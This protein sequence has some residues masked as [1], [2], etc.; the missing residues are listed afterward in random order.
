MDS[1]LFDLNG[2]VALVTGGNGG[3]GL[4]I[5]DA[6][7]GAGADIA[8]WGRN[9]EK[10]R[11]AL[12]QLKPHGRRAVAF[13]VDV[14]DGEQLETGFRQVEEELGSVSILVNNAGINSPRAP[15][16][17]ID[18]TQWN[19]VLQTNLTAPLLLSQ[20]A[21]RSMVERK[22]GKIINIS[23]VGSLLPGI[24]T[25]YRASKLALNFLT[26]SLAIELGPHNIQ[27]NAILPGVIE[28]DMAQGPLQLGLNAILE[29]T[30]AGRLGTP[31]EIASVAL[32]LASGASNF[33][34]GATIVV[35]GGITLG[36][37]T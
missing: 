35:D 4:A 33:T 37:A 11:S 3:I 20:L 29:R 5:A 8:I 21:G 31:E 24:P 14:T 16:L 13:Q 23:S 27:V 7:A 22:A 17:E 30:P 34:T 6:F 36:S 19:R 15:I 28:T 2:S 9:P 32:Y 10:S 1:A 25:D 18:V 26:K 12:E